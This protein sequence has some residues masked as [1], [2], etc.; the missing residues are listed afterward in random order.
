MLGHTREPED[1]VVGGLEVADP[2]PGV[3]IH[4]VVLIVHLIE[5]AGE[6]IGA[7]LCDRDD[8]LKNRVEAAAGEVG[9][10]IDD[11]NRVGLAGGIE[12]GD[13]LGADDDE[14]AVSKLDHLL[15]E[16]GATVTLDK[17]E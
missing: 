4:N 16:E 7:E 14:V 13:E 5:L 2:F 10:V 15:V 3:Q 8:D 1:G 9:A 12:A 17:V 11:L 6:G